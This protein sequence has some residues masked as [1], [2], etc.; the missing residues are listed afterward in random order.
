M[1]KIDKSGEKE[2]YSKDKKKLVFDQM[3]GIPANQKDGRQQDDTE[4]FQNRMNE[5]IVELAKEK[6]DKAG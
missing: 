1:Q 5:K 3:P 4:H 6:K 2:T